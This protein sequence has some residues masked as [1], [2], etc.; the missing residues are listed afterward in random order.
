MAS[1]AQDRD[2]IDRTRAALVAYLDHPTP[3]PSDGAAWTETRDYAARRVGQAARARALVNACVRDGITVQ[4]ITATTA[5]PA[6]AILPLIADRQAKAD[7]LAAELHRLERAAA[8][9]REMRA[10]EARHRLA[11]GE[12]KTD[13]AASF[14]V[15]R[16]TLDKWLAGDDS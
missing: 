3:L 14:G 9:I 16:V 4:R 6:S 8:G 13:L 5:L 7:A 1:I 12:A 2:L 15:T 10:T 11:E